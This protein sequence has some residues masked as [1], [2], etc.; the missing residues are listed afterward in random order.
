MSLFSTVI[1]IVLAIFG[2]AFALYFI[3]VLTEKNRKSSRDTS[4]NAI[5]EGNRINFDIYGYPS[6][7][8]L[9]QAILLAIGKHNRNTENLQ[10]VFIKNEKDEE[11]WIEFGNALRKIGRHD[12]A[13]ASL[14]MALNINP[15]H[16]GAWFQKG[17]TLGE[18]KRFE[19]AIEA[20]EQAVLFNPA[21]VD[22]WV[23]KGIIL[24][25][26]NRDREALYAFEE[27]LKIDPKNHIARGFVLTS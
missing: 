6:S 2:A 8:E 24:S 12:Q 25:N 19:E 15:Q 17:V 18:L 22:A 26:Q 21:Y 16:Y 3:Q 10:G 13:I 23:N 1:S 7:K 14:N 11:E 9:E 4:V 27:V 20:Y 5:L